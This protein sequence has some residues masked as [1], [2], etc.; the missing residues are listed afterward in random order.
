MV[1]LQG[2]PCNAVTTNTSDHQSPT[3]YVWHMP[4]IITVLQCMSGIRHP[5]SQTYMVCLTNASHHHSRTWYVWHKCQPSS[6]SYR[7]CLTTNAR[8]HHSRT[9]YVWHTFQT[10]LQSYRGMS[11]ICQQSS[12][13]YRVCLT[14][15]MHR[16]PC[17]AMTTNSSHH[18]AS[19]HH[20][21]TGPA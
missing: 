5:L 13:S 6:Q 15:N 19:H 16:L 3:V 7:V 17:N 9:G 21:P 4:A 20:S 8:H 11:G 10:S 2:L 18:N 14:V 12:Q 1:D